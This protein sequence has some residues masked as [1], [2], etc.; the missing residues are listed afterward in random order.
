MSTRSMTPRTSC[1]EPIGIS[2]ATTCGPKARLQRLERAEEV[3][4][5]AVEHVDEDQPRDVELGCALPEPL[6]RDLDAHDRVD[7]EDGRLAHAQR[8]ERVGDEARLAGRVE[9]VDLA[10]LPL[11]RGRARRQIDI[12]RACSSGSASETVVPSATLPRRADRARLEEQRLVQRGLPTAAVA[13]EGHVADPVRA[14][15]MPGSSPRSLRCE[16]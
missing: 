4:A 3:G 16:H 14:L 5:L 9:Q 6:R 13:D 10:V 8:A 1:S 11:E 15:C 7:D 2:V 12:W